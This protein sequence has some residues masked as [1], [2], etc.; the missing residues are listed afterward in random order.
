MYLAKAPGRFTPTPIVRAHGWRQPAKRLRRRAQTTWPSPLTMSPGK[1]STT[2]EHT[3]SIKLRDDPL[4]LHLKD[5]FVPLARL[6]GS[7]Q[8]V[9]CAHRPS[10]RLAQLEGPQRYRILEE[11]EPGEHTAY[12]I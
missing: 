7:C 9:H 12:V 10:T 4:A 11:V 6:D 2:L 5:H 1:K 3:A 8:P